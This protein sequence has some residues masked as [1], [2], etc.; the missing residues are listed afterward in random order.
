MNKENIHDWPARGESIN[1]SLLIL[2]KP[3][4]AGQKIIA[5]QNTYQ[6][7]VDS[8]PS[9]MLELNSLWTE[10]SGRQHEHLKST[11]LLVSNLLLLLLLGRWRQRQ[12]QWL[13][14]LG[15]QTLT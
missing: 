14:F 8:E 3:Y 11:L 9:A 10:Q 2:Y 13:L 5:G 1:D 7:Q 15:L 12:L 4:G 6:P